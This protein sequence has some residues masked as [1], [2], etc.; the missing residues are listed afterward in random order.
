MYLRI[1][2]MLLK[3]LHGIQKETTNKQKKTALIC[4]GVLFFLQVAFVQFVL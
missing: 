2:V 4:S 1:F 3:A